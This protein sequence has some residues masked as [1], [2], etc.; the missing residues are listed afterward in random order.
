MGK[1]G[2]I[3]TINGK[4]FPDMAPIR[5]KEG[6]LV[7][8]RLINRSHMDEHPMHLHG[9]LF[10]VLSKNGKAL[11]GAAV[12]KDTLNI[13]PGEEYVVAFRADNPGRWVFHCHELHH[14][15]AGMVAPVLYDGYQPKVKPDKNAKPE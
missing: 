14:A 8:V 12:I 6:D 11:T 9:H 3:F 1:T 13:K 4:T 7:K 5:I 2:M 15:E 10:Q